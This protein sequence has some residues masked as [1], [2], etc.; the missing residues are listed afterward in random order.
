MVIACTVLTEHIKLVL[1]PVMLAIQVQ[2][3]LV[4]RYQRRCDS[5]WCGRRAKH[6]TSAAY[7]KNS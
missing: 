4:D 7:D 2:I 5:V 3:T 6:N 1:V